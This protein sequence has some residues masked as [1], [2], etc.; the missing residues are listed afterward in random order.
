MSI[1]VPINQSIFTYFSSVFPFYILSTFSFLFP[2]LLLYFFYIFLI[3]SCDQ[4]FLQS[5]SHINNSQILLFLFS[6][7]NFVF[8][9]YFLLSS[10]YIFYFI[11][12]CLSFLPVIFHSP[13]S[14][15]SYFLSDYLFFS[16]FLSFHSFHILAHFFIFHFLKFFE[17][18]YKIYLY[19]YFSIQCIPFL[20]NEDVFLK[21]NHCLVNGGM[22]S[23]F[24]LSLSLGNSTGIAEP[25]CLIGCTS[26]A[27]QT[28]SLLVLKNKY[29]V[30]K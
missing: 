20:M 1:Y 29:F 10:F 3:F 19:Q 9:L 17:T 27:K 4:F 14:L 8:Q 24:R 7:F 21:L 16:V 23:F 13:L 2:M 25:I 6:V 22:V 30:W 15:L 28:E 5:F 11:F 18:L 26:M 12:V